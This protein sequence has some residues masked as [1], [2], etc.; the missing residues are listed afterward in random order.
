MWLDLGCSIDVNGREPVPSHT[1]TP[2][3]TTPAATP[4]SSKK[5]RSIIQDWSEH[6]V[7]W[8]GKC[9]GGKCGK[10]GGGG[11]GHDFYTL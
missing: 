9:D 6:V 5:V 2:H 8:C 3:H 10:C 7:M 4:W 11:G 1:P